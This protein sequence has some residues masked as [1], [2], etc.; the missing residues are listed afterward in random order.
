MTAAR[1]DKGYEAAASLADFL[2]AVVVPYLPDK[3]RDERD[4]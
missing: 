3:K 1:L 4:A 2:E